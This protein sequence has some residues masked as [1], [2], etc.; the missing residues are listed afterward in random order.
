ML[1]DRVIDSGTSM[2]YSTLKLPFHLARLY[3]DH[4]W[5]MMK[6]FHAVIKIDPNSE[7]ESPIPKARIF[8]GH[9]INQ[10]Y[11]FAVTILTLV[12][13]DMIIDLFRD[14]FDYYTDE[15]L[16]LRAITKAWSSS[17]Q[18]RDG[19]LGCGYLNT[20]FLF[21][22]LMFDQM[23]HY[24]SA[25]MFLVKSK[26]GWRIFCRRKCEFLIYKNIP[27]QESNLCFSSLS[28]A[29]RHHYPVLEL[30]EP[31]ICSAQQLLSLQCCVHPD[32]ANLYN[33]AILSR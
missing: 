1:A 21:W 8:F 26:N 15:E 12:T 22:S 17:V 14:D 29:I 25:V 2:I 33:R 19:I 32:T 20:L 7:L 18:Q 10:Q 11:V 23:L 28:T 24:D 5:G 31:K 30:L 13:I 4:I 3:Y 9:R 6:P 16:F 27:Y